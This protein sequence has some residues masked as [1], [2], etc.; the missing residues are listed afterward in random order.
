M[1]LLIL[2]SF[3]ADRCFVVACWVLSTPA[4]NLIRVCSS[5]GPVSTLNEQ[6]LGASVLKDCGEN[7]TVVSEWEKSLERVF[8]MLSKDASQPGFGNG[9]TLVLTDL[10]CN[11]HLTSNGC[12]ERAVR[13]PAA[14][15]AAKQAGAGSGW[16]VQLEQVVDEKYVTLAEDKILRLAHSVN[17]VK[18]M[19]STCAGLPAKAI[20]QPLTEDSEGESG[21]DTSTF[22]SQALISFSVLPGNKKLV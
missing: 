4:Q 14:I 21:G 20:G 8:T 5:S 11:Q 2:V 12:V 7:Q 9:V 16:Q 1:F 18:R 19:Q 15:K 3:H 17:Y 10:R 6:S 22:F 13:L